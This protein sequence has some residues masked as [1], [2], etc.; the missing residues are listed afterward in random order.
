MTGSSDNS[1][2]GTTDIQIPAKPSSKYTEKKAAPQY[3]GMT[4]AEL[5]S[6]S[7]PE[8]NVRTNRQEVVFVPKQ[9]SRKTLTE[10]DLMEMRQLNE[11]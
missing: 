5:V 4:D 10:E 3:V 1:D 8:S 7:T 11:P 9:R 2:A 6:E